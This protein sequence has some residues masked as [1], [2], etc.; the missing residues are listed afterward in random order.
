MYASTK[1]R[2]QFQ[3]PSGVIPLTPG[4]QVY[5]PS[6]STYPNVFV[7]EG[8][9]MMIFLSATNQ[10]ERASWMNAIQGLECFKEGKLKPNAKWFTVKAIDSEDMRLIGC[11][12]SDCI[13]AIDKEEIQLANLR[14]H[15]FIVRW[16]LHCVRRYV[17]ES[18]EFK[19]FTG[20]RAPRGVGE[21]TFCSATAGEI[22]S[23]LDNFI[24]LKAEELQQQQ[25]QADK[26]DSME[27]RPPAPLPTPDV[28]CPPS[29]N[30][31]EQLDGSVKYH[32]ITSDLVPRTASTHTSSSGGSEGYA[33]TRHDLGPQFNQTDEDAADVMGA[34]SLYNTLQ[35]AD[36]GKSKTWRSASIDSKAVYEMA[37]HPP[38]KTGAEG[39]YNVAYPTATDPKEIPKTDTVIAAQAAQLSP[40]SHSAMNP[41]YQSLGDVVEEPKPPNPPAASGQKEYKSSLLSKNEESKPVQ[42]TYSVVKK[43]KVN[44]P[45]NDKPHR[46]SYLVTNDSE[47]EDDLGSPPTV[48]GRPKYTKSECAELD[49][50]PAT[51]PALS[52]PRAYTTSECEE[53]ALSPSPPEVPPRSYTNASTLNGN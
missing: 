43:D 22:Y 53:L 40:D 29:Q 32:E 12:N 48:P 27:H 44:I 30:D 47:G 33:R 50:D 24:D 38:S 23:T 49:L 34:T 8:P 37:K 4:L 41:A 3:A 52:I 26:K 7:V 15:K 19:I 45:D 25:Q 6:E 21:Y 36:K 42:R 9:D 17:C 18:D 39:I 1:T 16:P 10:E 31:G 20:R 2:P 13:L 28:R 14:N 11:S 5:I 51:P 35:H 46:P